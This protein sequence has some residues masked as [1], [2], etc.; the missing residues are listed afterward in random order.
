MERSG[1]SL[2]MRRV[3]AAV[4]FVATLPGALP[5]ALVWFAEEMPH[6]S[7]QTLANKQ[8]DFPSACTGSV[9]IIVIGFSHG[10][11]SGESLDRS[12]KHR[13]S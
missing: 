9:C 5:G 10:S 3:A 6:I 12:R 7:G 4:F 11:R 13:I 1:Y 8:I 2:E